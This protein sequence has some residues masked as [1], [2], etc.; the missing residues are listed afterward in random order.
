MTSHAIQGC[1]PPSDT[2]LRQDR[3]S[4]FETIA[5]PSA[6]GEATHCANERIPGTPF[7]N[8]VSWSGA[9]STLVWNR[10]RQS[11]RS[12]KWVRLFFA[13]IKAR[14]GRGQD[15]VLE[16]SFIEAKALYSW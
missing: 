16:A 7:V 6:G 11:A 9:G 1:F 2:V 4:P 5:Q 8:R 14:I 13:E 3:D 15:E 10:V 12:F